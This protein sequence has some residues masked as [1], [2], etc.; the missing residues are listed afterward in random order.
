MQYDNNYL[1]EILYEY[2][3]FPIGNTSLRNK[4]T[5]DNRKTLYL[6]YNVLRY[7]PIY[8]FN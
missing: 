2:R 4:N 6:S 5:Y 3:L 1:H 8:I 7:P